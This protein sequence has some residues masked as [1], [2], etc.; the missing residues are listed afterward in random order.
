MRWPRPFASGEPIEAQL[1][2]SLRL[3]L[4]AK[5]GLCS[6]PN[7]VQRAGARVVAMWEGADAPIVDRALY[8]RSRR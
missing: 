1:G 3:Q 6:A 5:G 8:L 2:N 4:Q 7:A